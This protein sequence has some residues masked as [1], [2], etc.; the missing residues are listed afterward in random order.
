MT[1]RH[2][3]FFVFSFLNRSSPLAAQRSFLGPSAGS[4]PERSNELNYAIGTR[5]KYKAIEPGMAPWPSFR[6][7]QHNGKSH[8]PSQAQ[9]ERKNDPLTDHV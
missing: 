4:P 3:P 9:T 1:I 6:R 5:A 2:I 8:V 7:M